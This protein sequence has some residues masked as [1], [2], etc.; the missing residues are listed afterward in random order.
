[1]SYYWA[2]TAAIAVGGG[3]ASSLDTA[4]DQARSFNRGLRGFTQNAQAI[5]NDAWA[6]YQDAL[7]K[8]ETASQPSNEIAL[9]NATTQ[10]GAANDAYGRAREAYESYDQNFAP[11]NERIATDALGYDTPER[12]DAAAAQMQA[13]IGS[14]ADAART[15]LARDV[16]SRGGDVNSGNFAAGLS[17]LALREAAAKA[18]GGNQARQNVEDTGALRL[19]QAAGLGQSIANQGNAQT[20]LGL[21]LGNS[22]VSN[23]QVPISNLATQAGLYGQGA[24]I[25]LG[26]NQQALSSFGQQKEKQSVLGGFLTGAGGT[27]GGILSDKDQKTG[28]KPASEKK[29]MAA[30]RKTPVERWKYRDDSPAADGGREHIGPMAQDVRLSMGERTAP[31]GKVIDLV[32]MNGITLAAAKNLDKRLAKVERKVSNG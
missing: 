8:M 22:A 31:G 9:R 19:S 11:I 30:V 18:T 25:R 12:R 15:T 14:A 1:M 20:Q 24:Q 28:R 27:L 26:A 21:G 3:V 17:G 7:K 10:F 23:A 32:T 2:G 6:F 5:G 16:Q 13:D 4:N 29:A